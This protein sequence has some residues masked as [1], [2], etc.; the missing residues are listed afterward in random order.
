[1]A[2]KQPSK[3]KQEAAAAQSLADRTGIG[4]EEARRMQSEADK[5]EVIK[6][7]Q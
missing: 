7:G 1:M 3:Q 2:E 6:H 5:S 4:K